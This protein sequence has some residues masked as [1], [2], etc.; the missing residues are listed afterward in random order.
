MVGNVQWALTGHGSSSYSDKTDFNFPFSSLLEGYKILHKE[1]KEK[2][3]CSQL[4]FHLFFFLFY[5]LVFSVSVIAVNKQQ[6]LHIRSILTYYRVTL[7]CFCKLL[8]WRIQ[9]GVTCTGSL[10]SADHLNCEW[11]TGRQPIYNQPGFGTDLPC[12]SSAKQ[13]KGWV[14]GKVERK[15]ILSTIKYLILHSFCYCF[16]ISCDINI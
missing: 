3:F 14:Q 15:N 10:Q 4:I 7:W 2:M 12:Q 5:P 1:I 11:C 6:P 13:S 16:F 9:C 8:K